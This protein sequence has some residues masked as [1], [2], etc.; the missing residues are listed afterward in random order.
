[1][2]LSYSLLSLALTDHLGKPSALV[3]SSSHSVSHCTTSS[4]LSCLTLPCRSPSP[5]LFEFDNRLGLITVEVIHSWFDLFILWGDWFLNCDWGWLIMKV[6]VWFYLI[7]FYCY[8]WYIFFVLVALVHK[9]RRNL[10][11]L[12]NTS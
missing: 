7:Y 8:V 6:W 10:I 12:V 5:I 2:C 9:F 11:S 4:S 3:L 1:M